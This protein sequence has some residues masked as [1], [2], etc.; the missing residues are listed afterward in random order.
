MLVWDPHQSGGA[1]LGG[2]GTW[3]N[4]GA[5]VW[6]NP[7]TQT[8]VV[9]SNAN[10]DTAVFEGTAGAVAVDSGVAAGGI[11]FQTSGYA[12]AGN[13]LT[14]TADIDS[15]WVSGEIRTNGASEVIN[16]VLGGSVGL[17][18]TGTGTLALTAVSTYGGATA[19]Q[20]GTLAIAEGD[21]RLPTGTTVTLGDKQ[22]DSGILQLGDGTTSC[23]QSLADLYIDG[24]GGDNRVVGG[25]TAT[26]TLTLK[27]G[28]VDEYDGILGGSG[29]NQNNLALE[30]DGSGMLLLTG[31][32]TYAGDTYLNDGVTGA[33]DTCVNDAVTPTLDTGSAFGTGSIYLNGA[34]FGGSGT[35]DNNIVVQDDSDIVAVDTLTL[36]GDISDPSG[37]ANLTLYNYPGTDCVLQLGGDNS[38]FTGTFTQS[39]DQDGDG[40]GSLT[41]ELLKPSAGNSQANWDISYGVL[42]SNIAPQVS[43]APTIELGSFSGGGTLANMVTGSTVTFAI[44]SND[45]STEFDG[46]IEDGS[47]TATALTKVGTGTLTLTG[48]NTCSGG[49]VIDGGTLVAR[50]PDM[51]PGYDVSGGVTVDSG[52]TLVLN[53]GGSEEWTAS[54]LSALLDHATFHSGSILALDTSGGDFEYDDLIGGDLGLVKL[55][56]NR[57]TLPQANTYTGGTNLVAGG[58]M[59]G[60]NASLG[61]GVLTLGG[62]T[63]LTDSTLTLDIP[64]VAA[65]ATTSC[66]DANGTLTL[67]GSISGSGTI[68]CTGSDKNS[69]LNLGGDNSGFSGELDLG[70]GA[71]R[72]T[73]ASAWSSLATWGL[74]GGVLANEVAGTP[75]IA[76]APFPAAAP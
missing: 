39:V 26:A 45:Q 7:E 56:V 3:T 28:D 37:P 30:M 57:L 69:T 61:S 74:D 65:D 32:N 59:I 38:G 52:S 58:L 68:D 60:S 1:N 2:S 34:T 53:V 41:T 27:A 4:G 64:I 15:G 36:G 47:G 55:G 44:G 17:T 12:I 48:A 50:T 9:W 11:G 35:V 63:L 42:A 16:A 21:D 66:V 23:N 8:D 62:G 22:G 10:G 54:N 5:A 75:T 6:Y 14:L 49:T 46:V 71:T 24:D 70:P 13:A 72:V 51:L 67:D 29:H 25:G 76:L 33:G 73:S 40:Y 18:K 19:I 43:T 20:N 31:D